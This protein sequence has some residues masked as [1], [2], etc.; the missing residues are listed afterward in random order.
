M[1]EETTEW[2]FS[3]HGAPERQIQAASIARQALDF[4]S[5]SHL[6]SLSG[7]GGDSVEPGKKRARHVGQIP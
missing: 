7:G 3:F 2:V 4:L 1:D 5:S 6:L